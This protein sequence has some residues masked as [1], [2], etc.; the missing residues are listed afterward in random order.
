[1]PIAGFDSNLAVQTSRRIL[2]WSLRGK[3]VGYSHVRWETAVSPE[4]DD[5]DQKKKGPANKVASPEIR[6]NLLT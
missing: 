2:G 6:T 4:L 1:M 3:R 5:L